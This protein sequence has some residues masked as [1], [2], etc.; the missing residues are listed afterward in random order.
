MP[1]PQP[2]AAHSA[3]ELSHSGQEAT[4]EEALLPPRRRGVRGGAHTQRGQA[5]SRQAEAAQPALL[6]GRWRPLLQRRPP[7]TGGPATDAHCCW[8]PKALKPLINPSLMQMYSYFR[9]H[10]SR[11]HL[12]VRPSSQLLLLALRPLAIPSSS[13]QRPVSSQAQYGV[14]GKSRRLLRNSLLVTIPQL[15]SRRRHAAAPRPSLTWDTSRSAP[16]RPPLP[17]RH[18]WPSLGLQCTG[19]RGHSEQPPL[20]APKQATR[21]TALHAVEMSVP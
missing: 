6:R 13:V 17:T 5:P 4:A 16:R 21:R 7:H 8:W 11:P 20:T 1:P 15:S 14:R 2:Q 3:Q 12:N 9:L 19:H 10:R 18:S